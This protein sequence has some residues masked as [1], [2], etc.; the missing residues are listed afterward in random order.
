MKITASYGHCTLFVQGLDMNCPLCKV[1]VRSGEH[2]ECQGDDAPKKRPRTL[3]GK[4]PGENT[5]G[6]AKRKPK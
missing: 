3:V 4:G 1:L 5:V 6:A 2:H